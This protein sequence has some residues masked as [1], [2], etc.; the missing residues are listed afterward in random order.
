MKSP[1]SCSCLISYIDVLNHLPNEH[2]R[3]SI[4][5][6]LVSSIAILHKAL[7]C[8]VHWGCSGWLTS[9]EHQRAITQPE[10]CATTALDGGDMAE[11]TK[12]KLYAVTVQTS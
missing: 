12:N 5:I 6:L 8:P 11:N 9:Q 2:L 3:R 1:L 4:S 7:G 10:R